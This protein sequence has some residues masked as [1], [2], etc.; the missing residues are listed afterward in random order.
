MHTVLSKRT[1]LVFENFEELGVEGSIARAFLGLSLVGLEVQKHE[2]N[3]NKKMVILPRDK[4]VVVI[5]IAYSNGTFLACTCF[6][7]SWSWGRRDLNSVEADI[8]RK[9]QQKAKARLTCRYQTGH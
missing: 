2:K 7:R 9:M 1:C 5:R 3:S 6:G 8:L 4:E